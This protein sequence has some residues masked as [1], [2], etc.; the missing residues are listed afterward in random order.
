MMVA[1]MAHF[2]PGFGIA[3]GRPQSTRLAA[4]SKATASRAAI[5][6]A[7]KDGKASTAGTIASSGGPPGGV[8]SSAVSPGH[9]Y[10]AAVA[11]KADPGPGFKPTAAPTAAVASNTAPPAAAEPLQRRSSGSGGV[12]SQRP[13]VPTR[14][15]V[16]E[17]ATIQPTAMQRTTSSSSNSSGSA[18][19]ASVSSDKAGSADPSSVLLSTF[20]NEFR[21]LR[22]DILSVVDKRMSEMEGSIAARIDERI[23]AS[24]APSVSRLEK[25]EAA[26]AQL[27]TQQR[28]R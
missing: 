24:L 25:L 5:I 8:K 16:P 26:M 9:S 15:L 28:G 4:H 18:P 20:L 6:A 17:P 1:E 13:S 7:A 27:Q 3:S 2:R 11:S 21:T 22:T 14:P 19:G 12:G 10:A 23:H